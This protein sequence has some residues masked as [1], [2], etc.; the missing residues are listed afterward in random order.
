MVADLDIAGPI[1]PALPRLSDP[2]HET[3]AQLPFGRELVGK[4][5]VEEPLKRL[6]HAR[7]LAH[8]CGD[9]F[10]L[11]S[12]AETVPKRHAGKEE[13]KVL[14]REVGDLTSGPRLLGLSPAL[15]FQE[16]L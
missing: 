2:A 16:F 15:L 13:R 10:L 6:V 7:A 5:R 12:A 4:K 14:G 8:G 11:N 9:L 1:L 3:R